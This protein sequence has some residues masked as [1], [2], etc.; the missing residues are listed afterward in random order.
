MAF[1]ACFCDENAKIVMKIQ[2]LGLNLSSAKF[3][4]L[5]REMKTI[6]YSKI[7][8][9]FWVHFFYVVGLPIFF[10]GFVILFRPE[11]SFDFL[12]YAAGRY[13][14][15]LSIVVAIIFGLLVLSRLLYL[16]LRRNMDSLART[17][18]WFAGES[19]AICCFVALFLS[20]SYTPSLPYFDTLYR[21][22]VFIIPILFF[23]YVILTMLFMIS[24]LQKEVGAPVEEDVRL[25]FYDSNH[26]LKLTVAASS[27]LYIEAEENYIKV[28]YDDNSQIREKMLR[29]SM[30]SV[31][32]MCES[33]GIVRCHRSFFVNTRHV[34][35][36]RKDKEG[37]IFV[38]LD[39]SEARHIPVSK[40]YYEQISNLL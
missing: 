16:L 3:V 40:R 12:D 9:S 10:V 22:L 33:S 15:N 13:S 27:V 29:S 38:E 2:Y 17:I 31:E 39:N 32:Q 36:L 30:K 19:V 18:V 7:F 26:L 11:S 35:V 24:H 1:V 14:F 23:P 34:T 6:N 25:K 5:F 37:V 20:L 21:S 4:T 28:F 8:R